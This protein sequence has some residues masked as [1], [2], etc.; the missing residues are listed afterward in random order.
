MAETDD[1]DSLLEAFDKKAIAR[2]N[3]RSLSGDSAKEMGGSDSESEEDES[4]RPRFKP[5]N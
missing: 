1:A 2:R 4:D 3:L 5:S